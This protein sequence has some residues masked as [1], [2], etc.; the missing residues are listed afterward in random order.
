MTLPVKTALAIGFCLWAALPARAQIIAP[1]FEPREPFAESH[2]GESI[3]WPFAESIA[4]PPAPSEQPPE[5]APIAAQRDSQAIEVAQRQQIDRSVFGTPPAAAQSAGNIHPSV[6]RVVAPGN[7]SVS[8]GSGTL[9]YAK[10]G[11]GLVITNWHVVNEATGPISV[12]FPDGFYSLGTVQNVDRDWDLAVIAVRKP[13]AAPVP[14]ANEPPRQGEILTIAGYGAGDYRAASGPCTQYVAPGLEFPYEMVE[15]AVSARQGDSGGPIFNQRGE[16]AGVLFGEGN[17]RTSG[18]YC[19]RVRW[20]LT[21]VVPR[22]PATSTIAASRALQPIPSR[23]DSVTS[24]T[25]GASRETS[26]PLAAVSSPAPA[27][28]SPAA[29]TSPGSGPLVSD[30]EAPRPLVASTQAGGAAAE[31]V[32]IG[33]HDVAGDSLADQAKTVL[34]GVGILAILLQAL[35]LLSREEAKS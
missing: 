34:A 7:G 26:M 25:D 13:N 23:A 21:S 5:Y 14:I 12:H 15:V 9:I 16:L 17:G 10:D 22:L 30:D 29:S 32:Q 27:S 28:A 33:W 18:S 4:P 6:A 20:F 2:L 31:S 8:Y 1:P 19:G 3:E 11:L 24:S 35:R